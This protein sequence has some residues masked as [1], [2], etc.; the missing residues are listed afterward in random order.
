M[1]AFTG[2]AG[3]VASAGASPAKCVPPARRDRVGGGR[4][5][6]PS[7]WARCPWSR[8]GARAGSCAKRC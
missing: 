3:A 4:W 8:S 6:A 5:P 1:R 2:R 7:R